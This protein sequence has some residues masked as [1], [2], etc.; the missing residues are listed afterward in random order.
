MLLCITRVVLLL[1]YLLWGGGR[2]LGRLCRLM[3]TLVLW[4]EVVSHWV[5]SR[6]HLLEICFWGRW[7]LAEIFCFCC[8]LL[9]VSGGLRSCV[10]FYFSVEFTRDSKAGWRTRFVFWCCWEGWFCWLVLGWVVLLMWFFWFLICVPAAKGLV[11]P[12]DSLIDAFVD[13]WMLLRFDIV[14]A[15]ILCRSCG[16]FYCCWWWI[17]L[18]LLRSWSRLSVL[19]VWWFFC[20]V[21]VWSV[22]LLSPLIVV[23][24][25]KRNDG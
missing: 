8:F 20:C 13:C 2:G 5:C 23:M 10:R 14:M 25:E 21:E 9:L 7:L 4:F 3:L 11:C 6:S 24:L 15:W 18:L 16:W 22:V 17:I 1:I 19:F 12:E